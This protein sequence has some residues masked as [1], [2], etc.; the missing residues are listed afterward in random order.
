MDP[1]KHILKVL[2]AVLVVGFV[3]GVYQLLLMRFD[4]GDVYPPYSSLRSDPLGAKALYESLAQLPDLTVRRNFKPLHRLRPKEVTLLYLAD[5]GAGGHDDS[6]DLL[7]FAAAGGR[8]V[9]SLH[10]TQASRA[11]RQMATTMQATVDRESLPAVAIANDGHWPRVSWHSQN[12]FSGLAPQWK[13]LYSVANR[14]VIVER[15][16][17][18]GTVV[19]M[20]DGY[21]LS[22]EA[23]MKERH[24]E[25]LSHLV[26]A[27]HEVVFD[28]T[29]LGVQQEAGISTLARNYGLEGVLAALMIL[30]ALAVWRLWA[31]FIPRSAAAAAAASG[32]SVSGRAAAQGLV[33]LLRRSTPPRQLLALCLAQWQQA[34]T[35]SESQRRRVLP[36]I[37]EIVQQE[38]LKPPRKQDPLRAYQAI[39]RIVSE[40]K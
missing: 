35:L 19:L 15:P 11:N 6:N 34:N 5:T 14:P 21:L 20:G 22:N 9:L 40:R 10:P 28:E 8:L 17:G 13:P 27:S 32:E 23:L 1:R 12:F 2:A 30:A 36:K 38:A 24:P 7:T 16:W 26:G 37:Q 39:C 25:L 4:A 3:A 18:Q 31:S 33:N 29:H